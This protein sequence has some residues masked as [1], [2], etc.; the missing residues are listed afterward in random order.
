MSGYDA[1]MKL[2]EGSRSGLKWYRNYKENSQ[3]LDFGS[4]RP[5]N[6]NE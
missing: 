6:R 1:L 4:T 3:F 5:I 2:S